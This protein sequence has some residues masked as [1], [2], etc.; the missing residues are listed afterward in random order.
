MSDNII[1]IRE[2]LEAY[3][4]DIVEPLCLSWY[5][6]ELHVSGTAEICPRG[7]AGENA[8]LILVGNSKKIWEP[9]VQ[10]YQSLS[11]EA[12]AKDPNPLNTYVEN[13]VLAC[14]ESSS[15]AHEACQIIWS[16]EKIELK[17]SKNG[18]VAFQR[19]ASVCGMAFLDTDQ[20]HL[21]VHPTFGSWYSI[22][23]A[24]VFQDITCTLEKP[25]SVPNPFSMDDV[26]RIRDAARRA[27]SSLSAAACHGVNF[28]SSWQVWVELREAVSPANKYRFSENQIL[29]HYTHDTR[30]IAL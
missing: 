16:H 5:N 22:R 18:Y 15:F 3:G 27:E 25:K 1:E 13:A 30:Y 11:P 17:G 23:C 14:L 26:A 7:S 4:L 9:F 2:S 20:S 29:Y 12:K 10:A 24:I 19:M 28:S 21:S 8:L 6:T